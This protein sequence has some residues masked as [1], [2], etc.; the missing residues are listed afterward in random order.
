MV[1][2]SA[3]QRDPKELAKE[4]YPYGKWFVGH[5]YWL[6]PLFKGAL[7]A[8]PFSPGQSSPTHEDRLLL[9]KDGT[10]HS[11]AVLNWSDIRGSIEKLVDPAWLPEFTAKFPK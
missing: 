7:V 1:L 9:F 2:M 8:D 5:G 6:C 4:L 3:T 11:E 10:V